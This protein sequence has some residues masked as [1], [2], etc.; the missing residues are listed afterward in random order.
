M[1]LA[2]LLSEKNLPRFRTKPCE[3]LVAKGECSFGERC[4]YSH[5]EQPRRNP[6][7]YSYSPE[8]CPN[9]VH[10]PR[11]LDCHMAHTQEEQ[12]YHPNIY[13]TRLCSTSSCRSFYCPFAHSEEE[14][15]KPAETTEVTP[16]PQPGETRLESEGTGWWFVGDQK[17]FQVSPTEVVSEFR[18]PGQEIAGGVVRP[19]QILDRWISARP[20]RCVAKLLPTSRG[21]STLANQVVK[22]TKRWITHGRSSA[23]LVRRTVAT[24]VLAL[25]EHQSLGYAMESLG[26]WGLQSHIMLLDWAAISLA[27]SWLQQI[28]KSLKSLHGLSIAHLCLGPATVVVDPKNG[29]LQIGDFLGKVQF[30][31]YYESGWSQKDEAWAMWYPAEVHH[32]IARAVSPGATNPPS[33]L[34]R[35][36]DQYAID[37]WQLGVL[38]FYILTGQ[39]PFGSMSQPA[40]ICANIEAHH[41][42]NWRLMKDFPL[43]ADLLG[44]LLNHFPEKRLKVSQVLAHPLF[45]SFEEASGFAKPLLLER[46]SESYFK[47][48]AW[49][50][51]LP[52]FA[53]FTKRPPP[54]PPAS[55]LAK[56]C[57]Q[58]LGGARAQDLAS[59][60]HRDPEPAPPVDLAAVK[61]GYH[62]AFHAGALAGAA[63]V[64]AALYAAGLAW[65]PPGLPPGLEQAGPWPDAGSGFEHQG[66][67]YQDG[68]P[69]WEQRQPPSDYPRAPPRPEHLF[70]P[71]RWECGVLSTHPGTPETGPVRPSA[72]TPEKPAQKSSS[73]RYEDFQEALG[74]LLDLLQKFQDDETEPVLRGKSGSGTVAI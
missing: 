46:R 7:K 31:K 36:L 4:Q 34:E 12:L 68:F 48:C 65:P 23:V 55:L 47:R 70:Q 51:H 73:Q 35:S 66:F 56:I 33:Q 25:P 24:T 1:A 54:S 16:C 60:L 15:R 58:S 43:F 39:H 21:D 63:N 22:E 40:S 53:S 10:C 14:L 52:C 37:A 41:V 13:K 71:E 42:S 17:D 74:P 57:T 20:T 18:G 32:K 11:G 38:G 27:A 3:R 28:T 6:R 49:L 2:S 29:E 5:A 62:D 50:C 8:L 64:C 9:G 45:W 44:R 19:A 69:S 61:A 59:L 30:M 26:E 72:L 67:E